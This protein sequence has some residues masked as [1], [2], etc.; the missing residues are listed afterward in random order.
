[1]EKQITVFILECEPLFHKGVVYFLDK[2]MS[3][4]GGVNYASCCKDSNITLAFLNADNISCDGLNE[5]IKSLRKDCIIFLWGKY[6][7]FMLSSRSSE[8]QLILISRRIGM[9]LFG[10]IVDKACSSCLPF[11]MNNAKPGYFCVTAR[12]MDVLSMLRSH[13]STGEI[14]S[15]LG[16]SC[17]TLAGY[18]RSIM[19]KLGMKSMGELYYFSCW[20][21]HRNV[22]T[23]FLK[24]HYIPNGKK[25][26]HSIILF[27]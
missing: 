20:L 16:I 12:E 24:K 14:A 21:S 6:T 22:S 4:R 2:M 19:R 8:R 11:D 26:N 17:K 25:E 27:L 7:H 10:A 15:L 1:M 18:K 23:R 5:I 9:R 3:G 13:Y